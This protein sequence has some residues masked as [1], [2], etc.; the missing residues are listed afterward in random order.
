M[1]E[2]NGIV[3]KIDK[4]DSR[5]I[6]GELQIFSPTKGKSILSNEEKELRRLRWIEN[7]PNSITINIYNADNKL[8][9]ENIKNLIGGDKYYHIRIAKIDNLNDNPLIMTDEIF[10]KIKNM[11]ID[12]DFKII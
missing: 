1:V 3:K 8:V 7:N 9:Y 4:N 5:I 11:D 6:S 2:I 10:N 12:G